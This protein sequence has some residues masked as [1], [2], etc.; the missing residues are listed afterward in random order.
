MNKRLRSI[1]RG[2]KYRC[3][4]IKSPSYKYYGGKGIK[5]CEKWLEYKKFEHWAISNG[6]K[7]EMTI[8]RIHPSRGYS[9]E[10]CQWLTRIDNSIKGSFIV[11]INTFEILKNRYVARKIKHENR[12]RRERFNEIQK[13]KNKLDSQQLITGSIN[14][15]KA[16]KL[17]YNLKHS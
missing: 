11:D 14:R 4:N 16:L 12:K 3:S 2:M 5:V 6:Y 17:K 10:N 15:L 1:W 8:D 7:N 9:P 13:I